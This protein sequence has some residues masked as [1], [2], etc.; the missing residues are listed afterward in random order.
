MLPPFLPLSYPQAADPMVAF[1]RDHTDEAQRV[2]RNGG[3][4]FVGAWRRVPDPVDD[5][6]DD[7]DGGGGG[8]AAAPGGGC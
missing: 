2:E 8:A 7:D 4:K 1:V 3:A 5:D 6:A